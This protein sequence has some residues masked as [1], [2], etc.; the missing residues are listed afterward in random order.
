[1]RKQ[2]YHRVRKRRVIHYQKGHRAAMRGVT[3]IEALIV[4][5]ILIVLGVV[6]IPRLLEL[7]GR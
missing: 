1:M 2:D 7:V 3:L 5:A 4:V 6:V